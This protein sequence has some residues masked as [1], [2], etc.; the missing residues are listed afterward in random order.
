MT[1]RV[2]P[3]AALAAFILASS[4]P[5]AA[6]PSVGL[7]CLDEEPWW[8]GDNCVIVRVS[9]R[10]ACDEMGCGTRYDVEMAVPAGH[11]AWLQ[12]PEHIHV[13][14][15]P[16]AVHC[17]AFG[18]ARNATFTMARGA[19]YPTVH[20]FRICLD[21]QDPQGVTCAAEERWTHR[22]TEWLTRPFG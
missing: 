17:T 4:T 5:A 3:A 8:T 20:E 13:V 7:L 9:D 16:F 10:Q 11:C 6:V 2:L 12:P 15:M 22:D 19:G 21:W 18:Y 1:R 14:G